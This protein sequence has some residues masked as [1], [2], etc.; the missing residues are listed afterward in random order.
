MSQDLQ[1]GPP[2]DILISDFWA[3]E[4]GENAFVLFCLRVCSPLSRQPWGG[5]WCTGCLTRLSADCAVAWHHD[6]SGE[7]FLQR[8]W[9]SC[10]PRCVFLSWFLLSGA[11]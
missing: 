2:A 4:R 1:R 5:K 7:G 9:G 3:P 10:S 11:T 8:P 6:N